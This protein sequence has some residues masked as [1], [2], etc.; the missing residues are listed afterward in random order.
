MDWKPRPLALV[1]ALICAAAAPAANAPAR[2]RIVG[3]AHITLRVANLKRAREFYGGRLGFPARWLG[4]DSLLFQVNGRQSIE[5]RADPGLGDADR[6]VDIAFETTDAR[7]LRAYMAAR[8]VAVPAS[9]RREASGDLGFAARDPQ[10]HLVEF[11]EE[12]GS[13]RARAP[14]GRA[15]A[16]HLLHVGLTV[17]DRAAEDR[18]YKDILGFREIWHGGM[19]PGETDWVDMEVPEGADWLEYMLNVRQ[20]SVRTLG[21]M[22]HLALA[23]GNVR[24]S[25]AELRRRGLAGTGDALPRIGPPQLG[26]DGKW[27]ANAYDPDGTRIE[28]MNPVPSRKPCCAP[29]TGRS[30]QH[31]PICSAQEGRNARLR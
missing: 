9:V 27:Q 11:V 25:A 31:P 12:R 18:F 24:A 10:G 4:G 16:C 1:I 29:F 14:A 22:H 17:S 13:G 19:K 2:P 6:L 5:V 15:I 23:E 21:V 30:A 3:V 26:R 7:G 28:L 8:G 20:P